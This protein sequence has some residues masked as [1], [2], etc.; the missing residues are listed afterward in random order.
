M[1]FARLELKC[2]LAVLL[3]R[4]EFATVDDVWTMTYEPALTVG[5][6]CPLLVN[7]KSLRADG[8]PAASA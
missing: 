8:K 2:T 4:F 7:V 6:K 1:K 5:V 3:S